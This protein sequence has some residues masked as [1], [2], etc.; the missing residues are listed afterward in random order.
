MSTSRLGRRGASEARTQ[1]AWRATHASSRG[2]SIAPR[3]G[4]LVIA[5][6]AVPHVQLYALRRELRGP[7]SRQSR[8]DCIERLVLSH[9]GLEG[10]LAAEARRDLQRLAPVIAETW[11][12][13][14]EKLG[15]GN[16]LPDLQRGVPGGD[17]MQILLI[18]VGY[19]LGVVDRQF[20]VGNVVDPCTHHL[21][22]E[23]ATCLTADRL[24]DHTDRILW[25]DEAK[26]H[27]DSW[28]GGGGR[29]GL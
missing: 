16:R 27:H 13:P 3:I 20:L 26:R 10:L 19:R 24:G 1:A 22:H 8:Q 14:D 17:Q 9:A 4:V 21:A 29:A 28:G 12:H 18:E 25:L 7:L 2:R 11:K 6:Q 5:A 23:L 15:V